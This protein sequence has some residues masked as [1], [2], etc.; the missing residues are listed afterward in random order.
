MLGLTNEQPRQ[1]QYLCGGPQPL[2]HALSDVFATVGGNGQTG[3][4]LAGRLAGLPKRL[5]D[6]PRGRAS[7]LMRFSGGSRSFIICARRTCRQWK[8]PISRWATRLA[9]IS[10][11]PGKASAWLRPSRNLRTIKNWRTIICNGSR[12]HLD[13]DA[14]HLGPGGRGAPV[15]GECQQ[16]L[17]NDQIY[18]LR[19]G[20]IAMKTLSQV[21]QLVRRIDDLNRPARAGGASGQAGPGL[22]GTGPRHQP[23][24]GTMRHHDCKRAGSPSP[25]T[26]RKPSPFAGHGDHVEFPQARNGAAIVNS[27]ICRGPSRF[28]TNMCGC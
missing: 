25:S 3:A 28:T 6:P 14:R 21:E 18:R 8:L 19:E 12:P 9:I 15:S 11:K 16:P 2:I 10:L 20:K 13:L 22:C 27:T 7:I 5:D 23:A 24:F 1:L 26:G 17:G 4:N